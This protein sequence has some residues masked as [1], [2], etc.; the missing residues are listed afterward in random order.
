M[1]LKLSAI[2]PAHTIWVQA[3]LICNTAS[4]RLGGCHG[5][6]FLRQGCQAAN[7]ACVQLKLDLSTVQHLAT[8]TAS[9][10]ITIMLR[11]THIN[12]HQLLQCPLLQVR[13][14]RQHYHDACHFDHT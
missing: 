14:H 8:A 2:G 6:R 1:Q 10:K 3:L 13:V 4:K 11:A 9:Q 7:V 12:S 5:P